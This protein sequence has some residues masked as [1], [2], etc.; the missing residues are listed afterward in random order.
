MEKIEIEVAKRL[1]VEKGV[2]LQ[3]LREQTDFMH[4]LLDFL[5]YV[6]T[7]QYY[8]DTVNKRIFL[9]TLDADA[10]LMK[11]EALKLTA[12]RQRSEVLKAVVAKKK[13]RPDAAGMKEYAKREDELE[14]TMLDLQARTLEL[15][16]EIRRDYKQKQ[17]VC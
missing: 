17:G 16:E 8:S 9:I 7:N 3:R 1:L 2:D 11:L 5:Q 14:K 12:G 10:C 15:T 6:G 4:A 13:G